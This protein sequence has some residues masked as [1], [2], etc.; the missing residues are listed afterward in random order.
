MNKR[1]AAFWLSLVVVLSTIVIV[2]VV[3]DFT[4]IAKGSTT[5]YV[6]TTGSGGAFTSIQDA[7]NVANDGDTVFVYSGTYNE[8]ITV[9]KTINLTG[10]YKTTTIIDSGSVDAVKIVVDWVNI[11]GF[12]ILRGGYSNSGSGIRIESSYN[13]ITGNNISDNWN[14]IYLWSSSNN[15]IRDNYFDTNLMHGIIYFPSSN[16]NIIAN[17]TIISSGGYGLGITDSTNNYIVNNSFF[18]DGITISGW[19]VSQFNTNTIP[20]N[21]TVN[22]KPLY[23][24]VQQNGISI[25]GITVGQLIIAHC[26]DVN[27]KNL[28]ISNT[29]IGIGVSYGTNIVIANNNVSGCDFEGIG[30]YLFSDN[31]EIIGNNLSNNFRGMYYSK[32]SA[33]T[34]IQNNISGNAWGMFVQFSSDNNLIIYNNVTSNLQE[35]IRVL[36]SSNNDF[37][38]NNLTSN[39]NNGINLISSSNNRVYH[40]NFIDNVKQASDDSTSGNQWD[41]GYPSGG[42]YWSDYGGED[43]KKGPNQNIPGRDGIGDTPFVIDSDSQDDYPLMGP[44]EPLENYTILKKGWNLISIPLIQEEQNLTRVLGSIDSWY[45]AVQ[46][47]D[48]KDQSNPWKHH[49]IG[50]PFGNNLFE[51]NETMS[52]WI[53]I[54]RSGDTIFLYNGSTPAFNQTIILHP[55]WNMVGY[56]SLAKWNR[57]EGLNNLTFDNEVNSIWT[58]NTTT[59]SWIEILELGHFEPGKGYWIYAK[60]QCEWEVPL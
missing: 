42:N 1:V 48:P 37:I 20:T 53:H 52:F 59:K 35:G 5:H 15:I 27:V 2:D 33:N 14:G 41:D 3:M 56:P 7:I 8:Q 60:T 9:N 24:Y 26:N 57:T 17:N 50:K 25:D 51:I 44:Y 19:Q 21:N 23:Y 55:G 47:Y 32:A 31:N 11:T 13:N 43:K 22:G 45:D 49:K 4:K 34:I 38:L 29:D 12:T 54:N 16:N 36:S 40:N 10:E 28:R 30:L 58:Y 18:N 46:W 39:G 6:N